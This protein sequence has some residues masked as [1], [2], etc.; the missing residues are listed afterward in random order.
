MKDKNRALKMKDK[1]WSV[2]LDQFVY[3]NNFVRIKYE[4]KVVLYLN[5]ALGADRLSVAKNFVES[6]NKKEVTVSLPDFDD[7]ADLSGFNF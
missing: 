4:G 3:P 7:D 6:F 2:D 1:K 5:Y